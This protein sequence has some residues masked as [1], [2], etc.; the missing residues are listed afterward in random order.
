MS[1]SATAA[2]PFQ[3]GN[4][5]G[6]AFNLAIAHQ[7][8]SMNVLHT[9]RITQISCSTRKSIY[10]RF[11]RDDAPPV[12]VP[13]GPSERDG[14]SNKGGCEQEKRR[15]RCK[16]VGVPAVTPWFASHPRRISAKRRNRDG[17]NTAASCCE[18]ARRTQGPRRTGECYRVN[19]WGLRDRREWNWLLR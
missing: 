16:N 15:V 8:R 4:P 14:A 9:F 13:L 19:G 10:G 12:R 3:P 18:N 2:R 5:G 6:A 11:S 17:G 7:A 1:A